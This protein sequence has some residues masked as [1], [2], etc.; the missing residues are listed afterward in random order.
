M[1]PALAKH[2]A[3]FMTGIF[4]LCVLINEGAMNAERFV[5]AMQHEQG[6]DHAGL[7]HAIDDHH[8]HD[9][10]KDADSLTANEH[11]MLHCIDQLPFFN[12][13]IVTSIQTPM[14]VTVVPSLLG[15][16]PIPLSSFDPP[17]RP[18]RFHLAR[19]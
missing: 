8:V 3:V 13:S 1:T 4:M 7:H 16:Q 15:V 6:I 19:V 14:L 10:D 17:F 5:H 2:I 12:G 11:H 18:P 9:E